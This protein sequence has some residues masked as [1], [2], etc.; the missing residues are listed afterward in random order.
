MRPRFQ[1]QNSPRITALYT[2]FCKT[3]SK[4][5]RFRGESH[6]F[7]ELICVLE[8]RIDITADDLVF[9][10]NEG[11]CFLHPPM[12]FH[13][14]QSVGST[15]PTI[16][17]ISFSGE[18]IPHAPDTVCIAEDPSRIRH[19]YAL[20]QKYFTFRHKI[21]IDEAREGYL[22]FVKELELFLLQ[23]S[24]TDS[25][26]SN[27]ISARNYT[28]IMQTLHQ[29]LCRRLTVREI[30]ELCNMSEINLQKTFSHYAGVG[31]MDYFTRIKMQ[32]A[33]TLLREGYSVKETALQL[34]YHD[35]NYFSTVY[36][37][38]NGISPSKTK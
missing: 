36:K 11:Q 12:Q 17:V 6:D 10:L 3:F 15:E 20:A 27:S 34:G 8:G 30:A 19:L 2:A 24:H 1:V 37:R 33:A 29:N 31:V 9:E 35:Q 28:A 26:G 32:Y 7:W 21:W 4:E 25:R 23:L 5:Y 13:S 18:N 14:F 38:I 16:V 22:H